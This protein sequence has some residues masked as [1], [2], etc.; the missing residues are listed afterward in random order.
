MRLLPL[1]ATLAL[2][3]PALGQYSPKPKS[4]PA[5]PASKPGRPGKPDKN[6][7]HPV[8]ERVNAALAAAAES[9]DLKAAAASIQSIFDEQI[10]YTPLSD[11][12]AFIAPVRALRLLRLITRAGKDAP[13]ILPDF[14]RHP[15][16]A[17]NLAF[18]AKDKDDSKKLLPVAAEIM[19]HRSRDVDDFP[20]LAAAT[21]VVFDGERK[22]EFGAA[23]PALE[24]FTYFT[25]ND[26]RLR[27]SIRDTPAELLVFVVDTFHATPDLLWALDKYSGTK[28]LGKCYTDVPYDHAHFPAGNPLKLSKVEPTL[29]NILKAGGVCR[30]QAHFAMHVAKA[31]GVPSVYVSGVGSEVSH[32]WLGYLEVSRTTAQWNFDAGRFGEYREITGRATDPQTR[33]SLSDGELSLLAR[34]C[35]EPLEG[36]RFAAALTD[37]ATRLGSLERSKTY[38]PAKPEGADLEPR[39]PTTA[40]RL[41]LLEEAVNA[42]AAYQPAWD[43]VTQLAAKKQLARHDIDHWADAAITLCGRDFPD[44]AVDTLTPLISAVDDTPSQDKM[45]TWAFNQFSGQAKPVPGSKAKPAAKRNDLAARLRFSQGEMWEKA[46]NPANAWDAYHDIVE[47]FPNNGRFIVLAAGRCEILL[48]NE[49][50]PGSDIANL[51]ADAWKRVNKPGANMSPEFLV[52]SSYVLLGDRYA[53]VLK[54]N[55]DNARSAEVLRQL[56]IRP[57]ER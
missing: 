44:F 1:L 54:E 3:A 24:A 27:M 55:G 29:E 49:S 22:W 6:A 46:G 42:C 32:A 17:S 21:C 48:R 36:R 38:P 7:P 45:W 5:Q 8:E 52:V 56:P 43:Q 41:A 9:G 4:A 19:L 15:D 39:S 2:A 57:G 34:A 28:N 23:P 53:A 37:A 30:H 47:R 12:R 25:K 50:K 13:V 20:A 51:Y 14:L 11:R 35:L 16:F 18:L 10:A 33:G 26:Q 40:V 31:Q